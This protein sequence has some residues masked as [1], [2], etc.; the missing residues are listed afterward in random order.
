[1]ALIGVGRF[2]R[3]HLR[4]LKALHR[5]RRID[6]AGVVG[7]NP[8][9]AR[10]ISRRFRV[11]AYLSLHEALADDLDVVDIATPASTH[12]SLVRR[13]IPHAH[14]FV[15]KPLALTSRECAG[16]YRLARRH[17]RLLG[18][19]HIFR[20]NNAVAQ[21]KRILS[22]RA[23][24]HL[25]RI[26]LTGWSEPPGDVG[27]IITYLH[28]F[29]LLDELIGTP[30]RETIPIKSVAGRGGFERHAVVAL[31]YP[32]GLS[33]IVEVGWIG[34][35][36][37]RILEISFED[38]L[39]R[40]DL[41]SQTVELYRPGQPSRVL[42][43]YRREPLRLEIEHFLGALRGRHHLRPSPAEVLSVMRM[44]RDAQKAI[45]RGR[46]VRWRR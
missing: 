21:V 44:A 18:V 20:F 36:K 27:A 42:R 16:L 35:V 13:S 19:G 22:R 29:D 34:G 10:A 12:A 17:S 24:P 7:R 26:E 28:V 31:A 15:E 25:I 38:L 33:A 46:P 32:R 41:V 45:R 11:N 5:A 1:V 39:V 37:R 6:F 43:C 40:S 14:V 3:N 9:R 8:R 23:R 2:G 4:V 30:P